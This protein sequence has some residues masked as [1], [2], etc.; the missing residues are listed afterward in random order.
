VSEPASRTPAKR[1]GPKPALTREKVI[2][3]ALDLID[4]DGL[5]ALNLRRLAG[6]LGVSAMTPYSYFD[7]KADLLN[8]MIAHAFAGI[9]LDGATE[10]AW[11]AE[12]ERVIRS[13]H[14]AL[15]AHPGIL[16]MLVA[17]SHSGRLEELRTHLTGMLM[18]NG[19]TRTESS[20]ALRTLISYVLGHTI[21]TRLRRQPAGRARS[22]ASFDHGLALVLD[23]IRR[24]VAAGSGAP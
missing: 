19:L 13:V 3:A 24:E 23:G 10:P 22:S 2:E 9:D 4:A 14:D 5:A 11:D 1:P 21:L 6:A 12:L 8:A 20:D 7:D 17:E 15:S 18:A 16:D